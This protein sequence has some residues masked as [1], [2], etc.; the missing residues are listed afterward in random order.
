MKTLWTIA[1]LF[2]LTLHIQAQNFIEKHF[3]DALMNEDFFTLSVSGKMFDIMADLDIDDEPYVELKDFI[4]Q[5]E[6]MTL[7][8]GE[9]LDAPESYY[10]EAQHI[11]SQ[12]M[13]EL[14]SVR[15]KHYL[16]RVFID[17]HDGVVRELVISGGS[18]TAFTL[19]SILG[20]MDLNKINYFIKALRKGEL[21][22]LSFI[23]EQSEIDADIYP[24]PTDPSRGWTLVVP[25]ELIGAHAY[26]VDM[27]GKTMKQFDVELEETPIMVDRWSEGHYTIN[28]A[29]GDVRITKKLVIQQV[30]NSK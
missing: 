6:S 1:C 20:Q 14:I 9:D 3:E 2:I 23:T 25:E 11:A 29:K 15:D 28:I 5:I 17:E 8:H 12:S 18:N 30:G 26:I 16:V 22:E 21:K 10:K 27:S 4:G 13:E 19:V 24:N 7:V